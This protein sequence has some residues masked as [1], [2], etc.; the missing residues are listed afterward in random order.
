MNYCYGAYIS[1]FIMLY[2]MS[3]LRAVQLLSGLGQHL[4]PLGPPHHMGHVGL[5]H[6]VDSANPLPAQTMG[7]LI[8]CVLNWPILPPRDRGKK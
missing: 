6:Y 5:P 8:P 7:S 3:Y 2:L 4:R 1:L